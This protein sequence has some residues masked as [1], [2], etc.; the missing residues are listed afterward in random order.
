[1][2]GLMWVWMPDGTSIK[3]FR[4]E[5]FLELFEEGVMPTEIKEV[6]GRLQSENEM[7]K[8]TIHRAM[9][10]EN[11]DSFY[12]SLHKLLTELSQRVGIC[13]RSGFDYCS[14]HDSSDPI[15]YCFPCWAGRLLKQMPDPNAMPPMDSNVIP[16][17]PAKGYERWNVTPEEKEDDDRPSNY[18]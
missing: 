5:Q 6:M 1:M 18:T 3:A 13:G 7:L 4:R 2:P 14:V 10:L 15:E 16:T 8:V 9:Q 12:K 11:N 17:V